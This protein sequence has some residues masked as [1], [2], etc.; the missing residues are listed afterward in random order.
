MKDALKIFAEEQQKPSAS[1]VS[2]HNLASASA[3]GKKLDD[4]YRAGEVALLWNNAYAPL[5]DALGKAMKKK[6]TTPE[7]KQEIILLRRILSGDIG[8]RIGWAQWHMVAHMGNFDRFI[9]TG[10]KSSGTLGA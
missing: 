6:S 5:Y 9:A 4:A 1:A 2:E 8:D 7:Q 10:E 3:L